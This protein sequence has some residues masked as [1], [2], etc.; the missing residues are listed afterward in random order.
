MWKLEP[1]DKF[2]HISTVPLNM[3]VVNSVKFCPDAGNV[4]VVGAECEDLVRVI[5]LSKYSDI[6]SAFN[7]NSAN[8]EME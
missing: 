7:S 4:V 1:D 3:G 5:D 2:R 8:T 6:V